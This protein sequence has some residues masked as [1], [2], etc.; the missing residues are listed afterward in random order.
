MMGNIR[1]SG[2]IARVVLFVR[3]CM[4]CLYVSPYGHS[5]TGCGLGET[6]RLVTHLHHPV[7]NHGDMRWCR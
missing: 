1:S 4:T 2:N 5:P 3:Q 7:T 6:L